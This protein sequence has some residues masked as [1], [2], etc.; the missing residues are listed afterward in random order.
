MGNS[1]GNVDKKYT[2]SNND[3]TDTKPLNI[4]GQKTTTQQPE[5]IGE[6]RKTK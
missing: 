3:K 1:T 4:L 6:R 2:T 5:D